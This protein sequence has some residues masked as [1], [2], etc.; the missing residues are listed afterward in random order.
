MDQ[1]ETNSSEMTEKI[2]PLFKKKAN[3]SCGSKNKPGPLVPQSVVIQ[4]VK[5]TLKPHPLSGKVFQEQA[6]P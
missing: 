3:S 1:G 5:I 2:N 4:Y 6:R